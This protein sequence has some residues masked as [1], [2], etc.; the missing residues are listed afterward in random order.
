MQFLL[1]RLA[2]PSSWAAISVLLTLVGVNPVML[3]FVGKVVTIA[4]DALQ[5]LSAVG[6]GGAAVA[7]AAMPEG[8]GDRG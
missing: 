5:L 7:A 3:A 2:E 1:K 8:G 4:P 6:A